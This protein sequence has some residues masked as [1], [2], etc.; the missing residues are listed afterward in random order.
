[1]AL[2]SVH[3]IIVFPVL[4]FCHIHDLYDACL[5]LTHTLLPTIF[6]YWHV[7]SVCSRKKSPAQ[8]WIAKNMAKRL[9]K[10]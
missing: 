8:V 3:V 7:H 2:F 10:T 1:M 6:L 4:H 9:Y 5:G